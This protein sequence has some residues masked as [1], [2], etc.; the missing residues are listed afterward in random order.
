MLA[1]LQA[2]EERYRLMFE[3]NTA[4]QLVADLETG[5]LVDVNPAALGVLWLYT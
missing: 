5:A 2:S 1:A 4:V 3:E